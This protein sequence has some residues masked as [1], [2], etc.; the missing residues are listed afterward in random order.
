MIL[1]RYT[2][3]GT[4]N[5]KAGLRCSTNQTQ[6]CPKTLDLAENHTPV[7][8]ALTCCAKVLNGTRKCISNSP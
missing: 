7:T 4:E 8:N 1:I 3:N 2:V 6:V 5:K